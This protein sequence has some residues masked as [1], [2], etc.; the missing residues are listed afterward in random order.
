MP[1]TAKFLQTSA[2]YMGN[3]HCDEYAYG[4]DKGFI[5]GLQ[6]AINLVY[7]MEQKLYKTPKEI[8]ILNDDQAIKRIYI[9]HTVREVMIKLENERFKLEKKQ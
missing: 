4:R 7:Q 5:E 2:K 3:S 1:Y 9:L 6:H 8:D